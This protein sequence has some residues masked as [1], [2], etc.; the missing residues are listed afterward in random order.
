MIVL[1]EAMEFKDKLAKFMGDTPPVVVA[2]RMCEMGF[3]VSE[4]AV[5][6]WIAGTREPQSGAIPYLARALDCTP[7][8][9]LGFTAEGAA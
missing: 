9:L 2:G 8:D 4:A 3:S 1:E 5:A 7:N 6:T